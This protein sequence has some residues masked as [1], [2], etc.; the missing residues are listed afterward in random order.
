MSDLPSPTVQPPVPVVLGGEVDSKLSDAYFVTSLIAPSH[1]IALHRKEQE[2]QLTTGGVSRM[3]SYADRISVR[4]MVD[5]VAF[6][7]SRYSE[8]TLLPPD[9]YY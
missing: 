7:Q 8:R 4:Q 6:V 2:E 1:Q 5:L 9:N 3:P